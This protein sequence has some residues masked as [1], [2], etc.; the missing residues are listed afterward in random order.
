MSKIC[1]VGSINLDFFTTASTFPEKGE[2]ILGNEFF[3][4]PGGK[5]ANQAIAAAKLGGDVSFVGAVGN[6][7]SSKVLLDNFTKHQ[8][9]I[10]GVE[11]VDTHSGM[12]QITIAEQ[13]NTIIVVPGANKKVTID[14]VKKHEDMIDACDIVI[15]QME[16]PLETMEYVIDYAY[17]KKKT[18]ILNPA[19]AHVLSE[20]AIEK[21]TYITPNEVEIKTVFGEVPIEEILGDY[22]NKVVMTKGSDGV[23]FHNGKE[24]VHVEAEKTTPI[25]TTGAGD[26]FNGAFAVGLS[27][28]NSIE[29]AIRFANKAAAVAITKMGAQGAMPTREELTL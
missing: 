24:I 22:P 27:E 20:E 26:T 10:E 13:D 11:S 17:A 12:A 16:I 25:D 9:K 23:Y 2:T 18:I 19:P 5:G 15:L 8:V 28:G 7:P 3:T 14:L 4:Q 6:D 1:V 21:S 29:E